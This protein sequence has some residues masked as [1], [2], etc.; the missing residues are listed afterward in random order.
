VVHQQQKMGVPEVLDALIYPCG[1]RDGLSVGW[2]TTAWLVYIHLG[3]I[4]FR[5]GQ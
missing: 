1:H 5:H 4:L 2:L 3:N